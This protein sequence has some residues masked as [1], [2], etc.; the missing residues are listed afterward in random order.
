MY[1]GDFIWIAGVELF[2]GLEIAQ[3]GLVLGDDDS[4]GITTI[5]NDNKVLPDDA[6][7]CTCSDLN[8]V[9]VSC[10]E[11]MVEQFTE[12]LFDLSISPLY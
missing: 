1:S 2:V 4:L 5:G 7:D 12:G 11:L 3:A 10:F 9:L 6:G 8:Y